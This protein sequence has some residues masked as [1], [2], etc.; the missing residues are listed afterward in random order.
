TVYIIIL[1]YLISR[2]TLTLCGYY[3]KDFAYFSFY[4]LLSFILIAKEPDLGTAMVKLFVGYGIL[5]LVGV[6]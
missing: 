5:F 4:I 2:T 1:G 6:N 3:F